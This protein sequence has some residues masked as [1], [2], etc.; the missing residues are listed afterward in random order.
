MNLEIY[1]DNKLLE[2][3]KVFNDRTLFKAGDV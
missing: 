1:Y 2:K 3:D